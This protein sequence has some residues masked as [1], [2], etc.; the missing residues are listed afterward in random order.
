MNQVD[1]RTERINIAYQNSGQL[2]LLNGN[3]TS[4]TDKLNNLN[5]IYNFNTININH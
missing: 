1:E 3:K 5:L 4:F 2:P